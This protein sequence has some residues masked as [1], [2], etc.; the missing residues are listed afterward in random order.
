L[1]ANLL[2]LQELFTHLVPLQSCCIGNSLAMVGGNAT[3]MRVFFQAQ[4]IRVGVRIHNLTIAEGEVM[5]I[6]EAIR[7]ATF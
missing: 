3:S 2:L 1:G 5:A 7:V 4:D 6:L